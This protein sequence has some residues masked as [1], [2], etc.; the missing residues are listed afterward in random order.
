M[1]AGVGVADA[2]AI[3]VGVGVRVAKRAT[4]MVGLGVGVDPWAT[5]SPKRQ[6]IAG[7]AQ[8]KKAQIIKFF[9]LTILTQTRIFFTRLY[10]PG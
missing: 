6:A 3:M 9:R 7:M 2:V 5:K 10:A 8:T 1:A 4:K